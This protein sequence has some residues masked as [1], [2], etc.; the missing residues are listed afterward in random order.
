MLTDAAAPADTAEATFLTAL[1]G[2][3]PDNGTPS[4]IALEGAADF[5]RKFEQ[6]KPGERCVVVF[7]SDGAPS[8]C[9]DEGDVLDLS[10][11]HI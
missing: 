7:V 5:C 4:A 11:I 10:L 3:D 9:G 1:A 2:V 8:Q 6:Q